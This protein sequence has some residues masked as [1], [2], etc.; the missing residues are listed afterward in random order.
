MARPVAL[1]FL[2]IMV[3][4]Y[5]YP[6]NPQCGFNEEWNNCAVHISCEPKCGENAP[7]ICPAIC[8]SRCQ[9]L[10]GY[11]RNLITGLCVSGNC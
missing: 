3:C 11:K 10:A 4:V 8:V 6:S 2:F 5:G 7:K 1:F 9:C